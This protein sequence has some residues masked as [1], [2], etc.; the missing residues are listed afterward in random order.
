MA[1]SNSH[2]ADHDVPE[3][4]VAQ[5][6]SEWHRFTGWTVKL[7]VATAVVLLLMLLFL[8]IL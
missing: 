8:R 4:L 6:R 7:C 5:H 3:E 1:H 2:S